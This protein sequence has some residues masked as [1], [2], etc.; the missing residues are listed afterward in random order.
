MLTERERIEYELLCLLTDVE[1]PM[2]A[3]TLSLMLKEKD[4]D[5]SSATIG[6]LLTGFDYQGLTTKRGF[7]GRVL[8]N[9]GVKLLAGLESKRRLEEAGSLLNDYLGTD[10]EYQLIDILVA[11]R[12]I[13]RESAR[14]AALNATEE[15]IRE[16]GRIYGLQAKDAADGVMSPDNDVLFHQAI[17]AASKN[18]VLAAAYDYIWQNG[19]FS[20]VMEH[21][22]S[23]VGGVLAADHRKILNALTERNSDEADRCM[24]GH[25]DGLI[26]DVHKYWAMAQ[27]GEQDP[28]PPA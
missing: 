1:S 24:A 16:L 22:R 15:D 10:G 9:A 2:G 28:A 27:A 12:G 19:R 17:A 8:T 26:N 21:I 4:L 20:P 3:V 6:R 18:R 5:V 13:E 7:Q 14:L 25:I 11:R 23:S